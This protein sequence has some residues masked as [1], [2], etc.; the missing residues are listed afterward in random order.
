MSKSIRE[1][2]DELMEKI[3]KKGDMGFILAVC[4]TQDYYMKDM[5]HFITENNLNFNHLWEDSEEGDK[6]YKDYE[7]I[8]DRTDYY[9]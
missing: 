1:V 3:G 9:E 8:L 7:Q 4:L 2:F 5:I 6:A